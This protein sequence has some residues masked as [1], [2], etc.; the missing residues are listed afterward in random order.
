MEGYIA[1]WGLEA[2]DCLKL[3]SRLIELPML[4]QGQNFTLC[5]WF[6][7]ADYQRRQEIMR[8]VDAASSWA[9][10]IRD[11]VLVVENGQPERELFR[12]ELAGD[13]WHHFA[14][15]VDGKGT[16]RAAL[17][18]QH[19]TIL[20][21][22]KVLCN[23]LLVGGRTDPA[24][25]H[26]D[27]TFGRNA[28]G[29]IDDLRLYARVLAEVELDAFVVPSNQTPIARYS[30]IQ[31]LNTAPTN[32]DFD[33]T[34]SSDVSSQ[35]AAF[36]WDF[37]DGTYGTGMKVSHFY[38][39]AGAYNVRLRVIDAHHRQGEAEQ[40]LRLSGRENPLRFVPVF[41]NGSEGYACY[42]IPS[43]VRALNGDL[44]AF[45]EARLESC[46][47]STGTIHIVC[48]RSS[49]N[50]TRWSPLT[51][52]AAVEGFVNMNASPVV[53]VV[54]G[55]GKM[56]VVFRAADHS[57]WDIARGIGL[58]R[59]MCVSSDD[60]GVRWSVPRDITAQVHK[61]Y[62]PTYAA[63]CPAA[64]LLDNRQHDWRIQIP[65]QGHAIQLQ[66]TPQTRGRLFFAGSITRGE[67]SI[68][69]SEN[70]VFWSDDLGETWQIGAIIPRLGL[71]EAIAAELENGDV[72][73]NTRSYTDQNPDGR[74]AV[75]RAR[76]DAGGMVHFD[77]TTHDE[78]LIDPAVQATLLRYTWSDA[79]QF[80]GR[81]RLLFANPAHMQARV[82]LTVRLSYDEG[83]SWAFSKVIERGPAA[84][85]DLVATGD[86][87]IGLLYER[88]NT[89]GITFVRFTLD[90]L[91]DG[92]DQI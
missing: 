55:T 88:G 32:V 5:F 75:T 24:G 70:Y 90:W 89:G 44:V 65:A 38:E 26:Y 85:S 80:G 46:S 61:P 48:K 67:R 37:G 47:D 81:S 56:V 11:G 6:W 92:Q 66:R 77:Q 19:M 62:Q 34:A 87:Q 54:R 40:I 86:D 52:V 53:D 1:H 50:G 83:I 79:Q 13:G 22:R 39:F 84:Y 49:D 72:L 36:Q 12:F 10:V 23:Q 74:R 25:G 31:D 43:V 78:V 73:I 9:C 3:Y 17:N 16:V 29:Q 21:D 35:M 76:F 51:V 4:E 58:S 59:A 18:R 2:F 64:A 33:A 42:R 57:E 27:Y 71:N 41:I 14:L 30:A 68:F 91:S 28:S 15:T 45:A 69:D 82:N 20:T 8:S 63:I 60:H 7:A